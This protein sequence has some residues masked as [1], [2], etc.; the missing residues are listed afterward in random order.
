ME[1][2]LLVIQHMFHH[3]YLL[4]TW[5]LLGAVGAVLATAPEAEAAVA[6]T[7]LQQAYH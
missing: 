1:V 3:H 2:C 7:E 5:L 4:I 6:V